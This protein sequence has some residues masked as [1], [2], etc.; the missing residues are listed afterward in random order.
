MKKSTPANVADAPIK[1]LTR[2][3]RPQKAAPVETPKRRRGANDANGRTHEVD[4]E[5]DLREILR[6]LM[7]LKKGDFSVRL[8][9]HWL[10]TSGKVADTFN[11]V[12]ELMEDSTAN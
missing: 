11:E 3:A 4:G 9:V 12:A 10:G 1:A 6:A 5:A 8:P 7:A 2:S